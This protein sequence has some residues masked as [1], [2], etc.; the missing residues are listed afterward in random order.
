MYHIKYK[1]N[2]FLRRKCVARYFRNGGRIIK[3]YILEGIITKVK[4]QGRVSLSRNI[5]NDAA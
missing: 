4:D 2:S 1:K 3:W 5:L